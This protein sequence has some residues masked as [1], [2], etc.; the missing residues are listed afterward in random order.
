MG[1][2]VC[3]QCQGCW[4]RRLSASADIEI[5]V[6]DINEPSEL[7]EV[8]RS[9]CWD[10]QVI[11]QNHG[12]LKTVPGTKSWQATA[13]F[14]AT[15]DQA[16]PLKHHILV[17]SVSHN[18]LV[19]GASY[20]VSMLASHLVAEDSPNIAKLS[21]HR[22]LS[23][24]TCSPSSPCSLCNGPCLSDADCDGSLLCFSRSLSSKYRWILSRW[25]WRCNFNNYALGPPI[26]WK[27]LPASSNSPE[28]LES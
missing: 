13:I 22:P 18:R 3:A 28:C 5:M 27:I 2:E 4:W 17:V 14:V 9:K 20:R 10:W 12:L 26:G 6:S 15:A 7:V 8:P 21:L 24:A 23:L 1:S 19:K 16:F 25:W 11:L